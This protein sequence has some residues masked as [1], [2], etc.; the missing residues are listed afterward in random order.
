MTEPQAFAPLPSR[1]QVT[2]GVVT[3]QH[4][5][6]WPGL[7]EHWRIAE[8]A[9]FDSLW[10]FDHFLAL[11]G[12]PEGPTLET[13]TLLA[14]LAAL[15]SRARIGVLVYGNTHRNPAILAKEMVTVDHISGG[16]AI[17]GIGTGWN[18]PEHKMYSIP[19]PSAGDR[20]GMLD[21]ALTAMESFFTNPRTTFR[22][23]FYQFEDAP[24]SPKPV[25]ERMPVLI[26]GKRPRMLRLI[27]RHADIWDASGSPEEVARAGAI[28]DQHCEEFGRPA[29]SVLRGVSLGADVL[30]N[31]ASF[32]TNVRAYHAV[33]VRQFL[34][35]YP[36]SQPGTDTAVTIARDVI[37]SLRA[38]L[39]AGT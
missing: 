2:F 15:T 34:F 33:G 26:G 30:E 3:G 24:F 5:Y 29:G 18:E 4:Q 31:A 36:N 32:E 22:G 8:E 25:Q 19:F 1:N 20:V 17:L 11:Y 21:E 9:G 38:E 10:L 14:A 23:E 13:S 27:A 39:D 12:D 7:V 37:P 6:T 28:I 16:R 35:D